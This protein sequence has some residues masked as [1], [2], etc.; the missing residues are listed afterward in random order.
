MRRILFVPI[1]VVLGM[2]M[3]PGLYYTGYIP[4]TVDSSSLS[5]MYDE[6]ELH[7]K[8]ILAVEGILTD[9]QTDL[10]FVKNGNVDA[11]YVYTTWTLRVTDIL[12]GLPDSEKIQFKT[13]GGTY[14]NVEHQIL[15][16]IHMDVGDNVLV[17]LTKDPDS[18][19][20]DS[21]YVTGIQSGIYTIGN[22]VQAYN[23]LRKIDINLD[24]LKTSIRS[25]N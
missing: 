20:G 21:Y 17:F 6:A 8:S 4:V 18:Q 12:K 13:S 14:K 23:D 24:E 25:M 15:D 10:T 9:R 19:W 7:S 11:P 1:V 16:K 3:M 2:I 5:P 22:G